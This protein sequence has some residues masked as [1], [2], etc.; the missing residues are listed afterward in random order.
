MDANAC[1]CGSGDAYT[2]CCEPLIRG[3]ARAQTAEVLMRSRYVA[4]ALAEVDYI[5]ETHDPKTR[6]NHDPEQARKWSESSDWM[7]LEILATEGGGAEDEFGTV[8]FVAK[9]RVDGELH[10]H[11]ERSLFSKRSERW[12]FTDGKV[13]GP[14]SIRHD[15]PKTGRND[16][17]PCGSGLK[18][19]KCCGKH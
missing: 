7:G 16:P 17:C 9:Y 15:G 1:P 4:Y 10:E 12:Y 8:E 6:A 5:T 19:K 11:R 18:F 13:V 2:R 3:D 14:P